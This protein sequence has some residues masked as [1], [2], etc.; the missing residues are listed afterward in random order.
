MSSY[1]LEEAQARGQQGYAVFFVLLVA[2]VIIVMAFNA[3]KPTPDAYNECVRNADP[4]VRASH[5]GARLVE[6][7]CR[8][9][10]LR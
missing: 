9:E 5:D 6:A 1:S 2:A 7:I 8:T 10:S 4:A 3:Y